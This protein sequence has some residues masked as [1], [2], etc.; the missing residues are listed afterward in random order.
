M[1]CTSSEIAKQAARALRRRQT[2][3]EEKLWSVL[4][5]RQ[6]L[7][8]KFLRQHPIVFDYRSQKSF[9]I[10]DFYCHEV[11][12]VIEVDG[13]SHEYKKDYDELRTHLMRVLGIRVVRFKNEEIED[14]LENVLEQLKTSIGESQYGSDNK[15]SWNK[16]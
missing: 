6:F 11:K 16:T 9:F 5:N 4:R 7:G 2:S 13:K 3:A 10:A 1:T 14:D 8:K 15:I 12:L